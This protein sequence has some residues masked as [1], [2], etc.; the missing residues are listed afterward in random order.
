[1]DIEV[2]QTGAT[3]GAQ[4]V[5]RRHLLGAG[6]GGAALS[7]LPFLSGRARAEAAPEETTT[8]PKAP[9]SDDIA[10]LASAQQLELTVRD[11]YDSAIAGVAGW[12][13][14]QAAV[15]VAIR[16][17]HEEFANSLSGLLGREAPGTRSD[18]LFDGQVG[19]L[20]GTPDEALMAAAELES[21]AVATHA[22]ILGALQSFNGAE[23]I[24]AIQMAE[25]RHCTVLAHLA[26]SRDYAVLL[27]DEEAA[28]LQVNG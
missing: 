28:S 15:M 16:E 18:S 22:E 9:T 20:A 25:A 4:R 10:L 6:L 3:A 17:A 23:L 7:L 21:G 2:T 27:V 13:D 5:G 11:L 8:V 19:S 14:T 12:S 1:M 26:D 24:A